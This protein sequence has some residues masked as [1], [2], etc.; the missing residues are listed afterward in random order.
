MC[1]V[2]YLRYSRAKFRTVKNLG[3]YAPRKL[4]K[5]QASTTNF[6]TALCSLET[7]NY[8]D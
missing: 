5:K 3:T 1:Y 6:R 4:K 8:F 2:K 7:L